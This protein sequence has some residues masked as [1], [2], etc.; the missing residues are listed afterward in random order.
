M[1]LPLKI[2]GFL[3]GCVLVLLL[4]AALSDWR[5]PVFATD[6]QRVTQLMANA[7]SIEAINV[8]PSHNRA[9][10]YET[11]GVVGHH[12]WFAGSDMKETTYFLKN[13]LP[14]LPRLRVVM[15]C[16]APTS[17]HVDN[18]LVPNHKRNRHKIYFVT[19]G[20]QSWEPIS[21]EWQE[22][23]IGKLANVVRDDH[24]REAFRKRS[25][26]SGEE[27]DA[28]NEGELYRHGR[29]TKNDAHRF[30]PSPT[31]ESKARKYV[32]T[33]HVKPV[34]DTLRANPRIAVEMAERLDQAL[35]LL[36]AQGIEVLLFT[37]PYTDY[38]YDNLQQILPDVVAENRRIV[39]DLASKHH[40][41]YLDFRDHPD[42]AQNYQMFFNIDHLNI[43][44][45]EAFS[46]VLAEVAPES[47]H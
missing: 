41:R 17:L 32:T 10:D 44:G 29:P 25:T 24:W 47:F 23:I 5:A 35:A 30:I 37:P 15:I 36:K 22:L 40:I 39:N 20:L 11:L 19:P 13:L 34:V 28:E 38:Y 31:V 7:S 9:I 12:A 6:R 18:G 21:G 8:G 26:G 1:N 2:T 3:T 46:R 16:I 33:K 43:F 27:E 42:F 14:Q 45:A 4:L